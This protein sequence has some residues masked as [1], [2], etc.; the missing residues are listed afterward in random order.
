MHKP[1]FI[2]LT[3]ALVG[4]L[5]AQQNSTFEFWISSLD[6]AAYDRMTYHVTANNII[7]K[8]GPYDFIY[9]AK[10]YKRDKVVFKQTLDSL[11]KTGFYKIAGAIFSDTLKSQYTNLCIIDGTILHFHFEWN[12]KEKFTTLSNYYLDKMKPFVD[13]INKNVPEKYKIYYDKEG[14]EKL[15]KDCPRDRI[16]D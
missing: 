3:L 7:I 11:G 14:L 5:K 6:K 9:F 8:D 15:M 1:I 13:F 16:L 10:N 4:Q 2:F 12:D